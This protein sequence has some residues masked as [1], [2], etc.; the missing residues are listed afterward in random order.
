MTALGHRSLLRRAVAEL[1]E[2]SQPEPDGRH[3]AG[4]SPG[5]DA[6]HCSSPRP[7]TAPCA[8]LRAYDV[9]RELAVQQH[10]KLYDRLV[11]AKS[12]AVRRMK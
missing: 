1:L 6:H 11:K 12:S 3:S 4:S 2:A 8:T 7:H 5:R 9:E 10:A